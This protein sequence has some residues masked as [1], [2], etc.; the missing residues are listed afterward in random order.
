MM[1]DVYGHILSRVRFKN[2]NLAITCKLTV[3]WNFA[4][5]WSQ[6]NQNH[7]WF[8]LHHSCSSPLRCLFAWLGG[9]SFVHPSLLCTLL[10]CVPII[11]PALLETKRWWLI[12]DSTIGINWCS[13]GA[14]TNGVMPRLEQM[15]SA[16][17]SWWPWLRLLESFGH[18][19]S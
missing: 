17:L 14:R 11:L 13:C 1:L 6:S 12:K 2:W 18:S 3:T 9:T 16:P 8:C 10:D 15:R 4:S 7:D 5:I 19:F